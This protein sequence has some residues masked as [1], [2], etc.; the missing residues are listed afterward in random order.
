[1]SVYYDKPVVKLVIFHRDPEG[2][3]QN[4][5]NKPYDKKYFFQWYL[6]DSKYTDCFFPE[7]ITRLVPF[8]A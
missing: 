4:E 8:L 1:M 3:K 6:L 2:A 7:I 5:A